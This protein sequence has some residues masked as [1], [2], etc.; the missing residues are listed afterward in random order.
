MR[1]CIGIALLATGLSG[2]GPAISDLSDTQG[3]NMPFARAGGQPL[4]Y[5]PV[6]LRAGFV[7]QGAMRELQG[8]N[9]VLAGP[10]GKVDVVL[11]A[12]VNLPIQAGKAPTYRYTCKM[13]LG[14]AE[15]TESATFE[16]Q[17]PGEAKKGQEE[18]TYPER[19][20]VAFLQR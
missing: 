3:V 14:G 4:R 13:V 7:G 2:C 18:R 15:R 19:L 5:E 9:C 16:P 6:Q 1:I 10:A 8:I 20:G 17:K 12:V 11:P